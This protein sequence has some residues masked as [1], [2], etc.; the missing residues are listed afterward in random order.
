MLKVD[1]EMVEHATVGCSGF[2]KIR[3]A[4]LS[5]HEQLLVYD[6]DEGS[7][8][9]H[10]RR[11]LGGAKHEAVVGVDLPDNV[12]STL[13]TPNTEGGLALDCNSGGEFITPLGRR[14]RCSNLYCRPAHV[15]IH[16]RDNAVSF[17]C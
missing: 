4:S 15:A 11:L 17:A 7:L 16:E 2:G 6:P 1:R 10:A 8:Q 12:M 3:S 14:S 9:G 13:S 5:R